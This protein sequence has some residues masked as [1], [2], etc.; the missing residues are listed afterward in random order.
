ME[1]ERPFS[2]RVFAV[3]EDATTRREQEAFRRYREYTVQQ[4]MLPIQQEI[5]MRYAQQVAGRQ[6][7]QQEQQQIQKRK[8]K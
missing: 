2:W 7:T 1:M 3:N 5:Q 6:L 8:R 4:I